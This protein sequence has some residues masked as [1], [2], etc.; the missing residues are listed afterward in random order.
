METTGTNFT[1]QITNIIDVERWLRGT[2]VN[3]LSGAGDS[4]GGDGSQHK[5][6]FYVRPTDRRV[7]YSRPTSMPSSIPIAP[8]CPMEI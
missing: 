2:A 3:V 1:S 5:V 4:Y 6:Q 7:I 8:S